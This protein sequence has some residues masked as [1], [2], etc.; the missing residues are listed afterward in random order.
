LS[1]RD[2]TDEELMTAVRGGTV[3]LLG[4]RFE[5]HAP[6]LSAFSRRWDFAGAIGS[7]G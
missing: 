3:G 1:S 4:V 6:L 2:A 7:E 5:R